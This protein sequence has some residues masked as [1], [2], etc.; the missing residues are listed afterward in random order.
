MGLPEIVGFTSNVPE[1]SIFFFFIGL[2]VTAFVVIE[3]FRIFR[4]LRRNPSK[5]QIL[6]SLEK[7][8]DDPRAPVGWAAVPA[9]F[10][11]LLVSVEW[12]SPSPKKVNSPPLLSE[13]KIDR[14]VTKFPIPS[15]ESFGSRLCP[16]LSASS[17]AEE[18]RLRPLSC[19]SSPAAKI[20]LRLQERPSGL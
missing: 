10:L 3:S 19:V 13:S 16:P 4:Y 8:V 15:A 12:N 1:S 20:L 5:H 9:L 2:S 7:M 17:T 6:A 11:I 14:S 18:G